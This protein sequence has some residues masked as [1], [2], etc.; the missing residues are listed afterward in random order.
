[1][2]LCDFACM[3]WTRFLSQIHTRAWL[4]QFS[5]AALEACNSFARTPRFPCSKT[6]KIPGDLLMCQQ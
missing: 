3:E 1:M 5:P 6:S 4:Q 2:E